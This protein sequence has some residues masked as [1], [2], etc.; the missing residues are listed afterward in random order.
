MRVGDF[1]N[2][3]IY[4][5]L[6]DKDIMISRK[7]IDLICDYI[8]KNK[9]KVFHKKEEDFVIVFDNILEIE[10]NRLLKRMETIILDEYN[11]IGEDKYQSH[12]DKVINLVRTNDN[13]SGIYYSNRDLGKANHYLHISVLALLEFFN[14]VELQSNLE[15]K[16]N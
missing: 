4:I 2:Y 6:N 13:L 16:D 11:K 3:N 9:L 10:E 8:K 5:N 7:L 15:K 1:M 12:Y 14:K